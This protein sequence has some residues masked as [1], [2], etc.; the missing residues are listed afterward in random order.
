MFCSDFTKGGADGMRLALLTAALSVALS[1]AGSREHSVSQHTHELL[2]A[3]SIV[4]EDSADESRELLDPDAIVPEATSRSE[5]RQAQTNQHY[6]SGLLEAQHTSRKLSPHFRAIKLMFSNLRQKMAEGAPKSLITAKAYVIL[7]ALAHADQRLETQRLIAQKAL[8]TGFGTLRHVNKEQRV[9]RIPKLK[10]KSRAL[11]QWILA[12][13]SIANSL[14]TTADEFHTTLTSYAEKLRVARDACCNRDKAAQLRVVNLPPT[15]SCNIKSTSAAECTSAAEK[16]I[17]ALLTNNFNAAVHKYD[18][19]DQLCTQSRS[20][21]GGYQRELVLK[22]RACNALA[23][24]ATA[25]Q[26]TGPLVGA[27]DFGSVVE[28]RKAIAREPYSTSYPD[29]VARYQKATSEQ[30]AAQHKRNKQ[31]LQLKTIECAVRRYQE[32]TVVLS[33]IDSVMVECR[34][35]ARSSSMHHLAIKQA[36]PSLNMSVA[37]FIPPQVDVNQFAYCGTDAIPEDVSQRCSSPVSP[38]QV[39]EGNRVASKANEA[40]SS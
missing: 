39:C 24:A 4:S 16:Q 3:D 6:L 26:K 36:P 40:N 30:L 31:R 2:E 11:G 37:Q 27:G 33:N 34:D 9:S 32:G 38:V 19:F 20:G 10:R 17:E 13:N 8:D 14:G 29:M 21:M 1:F 5:G 12:Y 22:S 7:A 23:A 18:E 35:K 25:Q 28:L 15:A